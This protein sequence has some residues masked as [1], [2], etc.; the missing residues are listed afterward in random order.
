MA[1]YGDV[2]F[3]GKATSGYVFTTPPK[4]EMA[5]PLEVK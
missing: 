3:D 5:Q 2:E 4:K 1:W